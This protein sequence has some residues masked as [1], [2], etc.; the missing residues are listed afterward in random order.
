MS[1]AKEEVMKRALLL[2]AKFVVD[3]PGGE[4]SG[5][6]GL[7]GRF[8]DIRQEVVTI[9]KKNEKERDLDE[10]ENC[11]LCKLHCTVSNILGEPAGSL[12]SAE[13]FEFL[14]TT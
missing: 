8:A 5:Q 7:H 6:P 11:S 14:L 13:L 9:L 3:L 12:G 2:C 4:G 1:E 10:A